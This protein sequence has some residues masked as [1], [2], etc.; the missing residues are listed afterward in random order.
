[1]FDGEPSGAVAFE[2]NV[3][4]ESIVAAGLIKLLKVPMDFL[5]ERDKRH[6]IDV[7]YGGVAVGGNALRRSGR[8]VAS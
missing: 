4:R 1:L 8:F 3:H 6:Q 7:A 5:E 2:F